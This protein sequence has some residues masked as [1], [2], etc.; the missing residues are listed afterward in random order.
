MENL[1]YAVDLS[2]S[3]NLAG[4][5]NSF[6]KPLKM[7]LSLGVAIFQL[8][9]SFTHKNEQIITKNDLFMF[10]ES[11]TQTAIIDNTKSHQNVDNIVSNIE[12]AGC[13]IKF[14]LESVSYSSIGKF[15]LIF[16]LNFS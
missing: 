12:R 1:K 4:F 6:I 2:D 9:K 14:C 5:K 10:L 8:L 11:Y 3:M 13:P 15:L 7:D 16:L